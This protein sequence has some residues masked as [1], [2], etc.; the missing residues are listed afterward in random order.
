MFAQTHSTRSFRFRSWSRKS[1]GA[2]N[3]IGR[4]VTIGNLKNIVAD[5]LLRKQKTVETD[6]YIVSSAENY[7]EEWDDPFEDQQQQ[8]LALAAV[9]HYKKNACGQHKQFPGLLY[10]RWLEATI[11]V[12]FGHFSFNYKAKSKKKSND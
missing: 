5:T 1:Y 11:Y 10:N 9:T 3:S 6:V 8:L 12:A 4:H 2:F 7:F